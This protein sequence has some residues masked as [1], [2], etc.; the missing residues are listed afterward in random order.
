MSNQT[1]KVIQGEIVSL[2]AEF[3]ANFYLPLLLLD[4]AHLRPMRFYEGGY[5]SRE[6]NRRIDLFG[7]RRMNQQQGWAAIE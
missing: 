5:Q 4:I 3:A 1:F 2:V 7:G 6:P